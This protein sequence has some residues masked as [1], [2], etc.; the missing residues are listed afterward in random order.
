MTRPPSSG[1]ISLRR[2]P[3]DRP[4]SSGKTSFPILLHAHHAGVTQQSSNPTPVP[5]SSIPRPEPPTGPRHIRAHL[6]THGS[7]GTNTGRPRRIHT[8]KRSNKPRFMH[9]KS[10]SDCRREPIHPP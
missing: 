4:P 5:A 9:F 3:D 6:T 2:P 10:H 1:N 7:A 8:G